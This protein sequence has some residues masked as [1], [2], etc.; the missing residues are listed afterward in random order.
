MTYMEHGNLKLREQFIAALERRLLTG[1]VP[2]YIFPDLDGLF[3]RVNGARKC[4]FY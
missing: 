4:R 1:R 3:G 2:H